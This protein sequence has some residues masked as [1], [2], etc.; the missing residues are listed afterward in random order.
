MNKHPSVV[1]AMI[2][3]RECKLDSVNTD[4]LTIFDAALKYDGPL[5]PSEERL[6]RLVLSHARASRGPY[7]QEVNEKPEVANFNSY[8]DRVNTLLLVWTLVITV[9][10]AAGITV[11]GGYNDSDPYGGMTTLV[12]SSVFHAV[13]T[14]HT[15]ATPHECDTT[16]A[17]EITRKPSPRIGQPREK[18][19]QENK[20]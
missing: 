1:Y 19:K 15:T 18:G 14:K 6:T 3:R 20:E 10:F 8:K 2:Q 7:P 5:P 17:A 4:G 9:T 11:P 13:V 16:N 12:K